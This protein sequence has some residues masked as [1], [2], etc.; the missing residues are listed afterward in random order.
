MCSM[1]GLLHRLITVV[2]VPWI[3]TETLRFVGSGL[4]G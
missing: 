4:V 1:M 2:L 3:H